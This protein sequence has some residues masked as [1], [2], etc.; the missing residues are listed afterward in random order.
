ML[1]IG[2][3]VLPASAQQ[4][5]GG[6]STVRA[7]VLQ[8]VPKDVVATKIEQRTRGVLVTGHAKEHDDV[9][10]FMRSLGNLVST[11]RGLARVVERSAE[12]KTVRVELLD[13]EAGAIELSAKELSNL[14]VELLSAERNRTEGGRIDFVL[15]VQPK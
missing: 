1:A 13:G 2:G 8:V 10:E 5:D 15:L 4:V 3:L 12:R 11:P 7:A 6:A 9:A 14:E